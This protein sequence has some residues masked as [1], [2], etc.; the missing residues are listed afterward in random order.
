MSE[1]AALEEHA[2][3]EFCNAYN[4]QHSAHMAYAGRCQPPLPDTRCTLDGHDIYVEV[5]H[6]YGPP[7]DAKR[8]LGRQGR[9]YPSSE[10]EQHARLT[11]LSDRIGQELLTVLR[12]K[13]EKKYDGDCVWLLIQNANP[14]WECFDF[15]SYLADI[16]MPRKHL[17][18]QVWLLCG[19]GTGR[20]IVNL[21][22]DLRI[23]PR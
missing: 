1:K 7:S 5:A 14:L 17:F 6:L 2:V 9:S 20:G 4:A 15:E 23:S 3:I 11:P 12:C 13:C 16:N 18:R 21:C 8:L 19:R 10:E 22:R